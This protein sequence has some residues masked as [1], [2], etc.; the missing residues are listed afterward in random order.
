[1]RVRALRDPRSFSQVLSRF[2]F[3]HA[4]LYDSVEVSGAL[5]LN[6][7]LRVAVAF[8]AF[9]PGR[10]SDY[11]LTKLHRF[12][13]EGYGLDIALFSLSPR[14]HGLGPKTRFSVEG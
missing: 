8:P 9:R 10:P 5:A 7:P 13:P 1:M 12:T 4:T 6:V 11:T 14:P 2:G 3:G